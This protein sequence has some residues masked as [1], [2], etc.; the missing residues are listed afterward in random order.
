[1]SDIEAQWEDYEEE[2]SEWMDNAET[3]LKPICEDYFNAE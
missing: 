2:V 1:L 3:D